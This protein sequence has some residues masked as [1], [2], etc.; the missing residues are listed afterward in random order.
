MQKTGRT[1]GFTT[2]QV[3]AVNATVDVIYPPG[4]TRSG[5][6]ILTT[7]MS[8]DGDSGSLVSNLDGIGVI[9]MLFAGSTVDTVVSFFDLVERS[10]VSG[11]SA[12]SLLTSSA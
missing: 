7:K 3:T 9:G 12:L 11:F 8:L 5:L 4:T 10:L 2:G 1:T 6:Q